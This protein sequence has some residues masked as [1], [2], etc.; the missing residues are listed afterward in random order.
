MADMADA[1]NASDKTARV[2]KMAISRFFARRDETAEAMWN[3]VTMPPVTE[4]L[5]WP[6]DVLQRA[7]DEVAAMMAKDDRNGVWV[8][9]EQH[10]PDYG[11][12]CRMMG[13]NTATGQ[14]DYVTVRVRACQGSRCTVSWFSAVEK[15]EL[16]ADIPATMVEVYRWKL[17]TDERLALIRNIRA[18]H[19]REDNRLTVPPSVL[20]MRNELK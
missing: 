5:G 7:D 8:T 6:E 15:R 1:I 4:K 16:Q 3:R 19:L 10:R 11:D 17:S 14:P 12:D 2:N 9:A 13:V 18:R 20:K